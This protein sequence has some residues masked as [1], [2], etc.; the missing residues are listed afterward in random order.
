VARAVRGGPCAL[1]SAS[2]V[3]PAEPVLGI[4]KGFIVRDPDGHVLK[5]VQP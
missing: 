5:V 1:L 3:A 4:S 2:V